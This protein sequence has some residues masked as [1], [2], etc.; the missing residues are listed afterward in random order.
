MSEKKEEETEPLDR[1]Y[2]IELDGIQNHP[3]VKNIKIK[4]E[5]S[6]ERNTKDDEYSMKFSITHG[7]IC[8]E[9]IN[10]QDAIDRVKNIKS[11]I[12]NF[13]DKTFETNR[14]LWDWKNMRIETY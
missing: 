12:L 1:F 2:T 7:T 3:S 9:S 13:L 8:Y 11:T 6:F 4:V 5:L 14:V 10:T